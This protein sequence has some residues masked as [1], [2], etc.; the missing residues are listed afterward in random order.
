MVVDHA[1][2]PS[3][4]THIPRKVNPADHLSRQSILSA[5]FIKD[6]VRAENNKLAEQMTVPTDASKQ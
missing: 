6:Q 5:N 4:G 1:G 2:L 3:G